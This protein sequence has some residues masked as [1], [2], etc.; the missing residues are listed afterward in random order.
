MSNDFNIVVLIS[1]R[2]SN[3]LSLIEQA[4]N[5]RISAVITDNPEAGGLAFAKKSNIDAL[6]VA[7]N[8]FD[9]AATYRQALAKAV[10]SFGPNLVALAGFMQIVKAP[11]L[12]EFSNKI[13]NIHP[14]LLPKLPG[15]DTHKRA[16]EAGATE[17][18][19]TVHVVDAGMDTGPIIAQAKCMIENGDTE[20][21]L[22]ARVLTLE[23]K[24]YPW[25]VNGI[26][27]G[28]IT[29]LPGLVKFSA[30]ARS[31]AKNLKFLLS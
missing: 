9:S 15:L 10:S 13:I 5:Y 27:S 24:L 26:A 4:R 12:T 1:G 6:V 29:I 30:Q 8:D 18:G 17:H 19:C 28:D 25:I 3:F 22:A 21:S 7:R 11:L 23:H 31:D 20:Q 16:L 2:G 14:S